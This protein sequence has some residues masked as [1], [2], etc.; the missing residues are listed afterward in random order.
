MSLNVLPIDKVNLSCPV[1]DGRTS[2]FIREAFDDRYGQPDIFNL[3][4][5]EKCGH[6]M[7][8]PRL[9]EAELGALYSNYYP[10]KHVV[11]RELS[12]EARHAASRF[13]RL[14][15]WWNGTNNQGQYLVSAQERMLDVGC[16]S[17]LS[18]LEAKEI[19]AE[20]YGIEADPNVKRIADELELNIHIGSLHD[21]PFPDISFDLIV[22]NQVIEHIPEPEK[23][24][25]ALKERLS[26]HGRL[27]L[28]L[29]NRQSLW[30]MLFGSKWINWHIPYHLHHF[31][32]A[33]IRAL[34]IRKGY[35]VLRQR[36]I[37]PNVW[38]ILQLKSSKKIP[39][40]GIPG[41]I[42]KTESEEVEGSETKVGTQCGS[43]GFTR[44]VRNFIKVGAFF[45]LSLLNR[46]VDSIGFGDSILLELGIEEEK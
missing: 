40:I 29:P 11:A 39:V 13:A 8:A 37:T 38:T 43:I 17:G 45:H 2:T 44:M 21:Y 22:L 1:C 33:G 36:T 26:P 18:L 15:R 20:P 10:R 3:V 23:A 27:V 19:G 41:E 4:R 30:Q 14:R 32:T 35:R 42:W 7:T 25:E 6:V 9:V 5:C 34:A 24:L 12:L 31:D 28:V 16:G 46:I